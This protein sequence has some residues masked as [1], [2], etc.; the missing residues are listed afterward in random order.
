MKFQV[1]PG[2]LTLF[3]PNMPVAG[4]VAHLP[5]MQV[6]SSLA[7]KLKPTNRSGQPKLPLCLASDGLARMAS[8]RKSNPT[9]NTKED[10]GLVWLP[11]RYCLLSVAFHVWALTSCS[12][13]CGTSWVQK[14]SRSGV[15]TQLMAWTVN[16]S[17]A[18]QGW[19]LSF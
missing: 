17:F 3:L 6:S 13:L 8:I 19:V 12:Y 2:R 7:L 14:D 4:S 18:A 9:K 10:M 11:L 1:L 5:S 16:S 15:H